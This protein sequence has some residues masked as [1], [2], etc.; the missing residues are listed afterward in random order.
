MIVLKMLSEQVFRLINLSEEIG[1]EENYLL[2]DLTLDW[3]Q[4]DNLF[5]N[6]GEMRR[7][8]SELFFLIF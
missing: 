8:I 1:I 6:S 2:K 5:E 4:I 7:I 3:H